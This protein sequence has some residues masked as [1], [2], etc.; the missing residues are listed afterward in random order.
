VNENPKIEIDVRALRAALRACEAEARA[1][2]VARE[3][4]RALEVAS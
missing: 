1:E 2:R 3:F 4:P